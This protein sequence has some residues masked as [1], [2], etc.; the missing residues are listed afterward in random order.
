[1]DGCLFNQALEQDGYLK[2]SLPGNHTI[3][4]L[5][6]SFWADRIT[7]IHDSANDF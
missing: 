4:V 6:G 1:M 7:G 3:N 2:A 5:S